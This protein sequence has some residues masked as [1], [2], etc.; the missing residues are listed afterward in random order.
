MTDTVMLRQEPE[1]RR[2]L[3]EMCLTCP[4]F[5]AC[6]AEYQATG[7]RT[8]PGI[9]AGVY[10]VATHAGGGR[11][12]MPSAKQEVT[13]EMVRQSRSHRNGLAARQIP[14]EVHEALWR[15]RREVTVPAFA[16]NVVALADALRAV[17]RLTHGMPELQRHVAV[18]LA[19]G[20][21]RDSA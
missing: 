14:H 20:A 11:R 8:P 16:E 2:Q 13:D 17:V 6:D 5:L 21:M 10:V 19:N 3:Q 4:A 1:V 18:A 7:S 9:V 12:T 15:T